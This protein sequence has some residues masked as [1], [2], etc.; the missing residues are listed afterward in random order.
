M[1]RGL[2]EGEQPLSVGDRVLEGMIHCSVSEGMI[3]CSVL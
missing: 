1:F 3:R 2:T